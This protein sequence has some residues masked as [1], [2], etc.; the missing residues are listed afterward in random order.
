MAVESRI[1][2]SVSWEE[3]F[4]NVGEH[5]ERRAAKE[6]GARHFEK[7]KHDARRGAGWLNKL[8]K[9]TPWRCA[10]SERLEERCMPMQRAEQQSEGRKGQWQVVHE[11]Q[12]QITQDRGKTNCSG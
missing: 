1:E 6:H 12:K 2:I 11:L 3:W 5:T 7:F 10:E 4:E 9:P 8:T